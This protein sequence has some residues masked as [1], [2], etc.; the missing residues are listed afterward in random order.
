M[1]FAIVSAPRIDAPQ[2]A[3]L[4]VPW[5]LAALVVSTSAAAIGVAI[6]VRR[7]RELG[8][9]SERLQGLDDIR[10]SLQEMARARGDLDLRRIEHV[11]IEI[12]DGQRRLEDAILRATQTPPAPTADPRAPDTLGLS[13]RIVQRLL[14]HGY[15]RVHVVPTLEQLSAMFAAEG[16]HEVLVEARRGGVLCKGR[17]LVRDGAVTDVELKPAYTMFP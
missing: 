7:L 5:L 3:V 12:R 16:A 17:V 9:A 13:E 6:L 11:L 1:P 2:W 15:E 14:A 10:S 8:T 4:A